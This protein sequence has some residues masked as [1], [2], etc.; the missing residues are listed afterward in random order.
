MAHTLAYDGIVMG[1]TQAGKPLRGERVTR[2]ASATMPSLP[3]DG[4]NSEAFFHHAAQ[5]LMDTLPRS[6]RR[7]LEG[8]D[9]AV[10]PDAIAPVVV[11][12]FA[13]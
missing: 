9:H 4:G 7:T 3:L 8:Q 5:A 2:W 6:Q 1:D 10:A 13:G 11:E 12:F